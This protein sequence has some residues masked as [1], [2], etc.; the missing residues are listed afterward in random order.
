MRHF[1]RKARMSCASK[2]GAGRGTHDGLAHLQ[3]RGRV[4]LVDLVLHTQLCAQH[5]AMLALLNDTAVRGCLSAQRC[6]KPHEKAYLFRTRN[7]GARTERGDCQ[8]EREGTRRWRAREKSRARLPPAFRCCRI[9]PVLE[10]SHASRSFRSWHTFHGLHR[11]GQGGCRGRRGGGGG[12]GGCD[13]R[14]RRTRARRWNHLGPGD[15]GRMPAR[16]RQRI[17]PAHATK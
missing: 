6:A 8:E 1:P 13:E 5:R 2:Q 9:F 4:H 11:E 14:R 17:S 7:V 10:L 12:R 15:A 3:V 16:M